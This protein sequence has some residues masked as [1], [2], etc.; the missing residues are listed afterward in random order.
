MTA[1]SLF[2]IAIAL[3][4]DAF[5]LAL[6]MGLT[7]FRHKRVLLFPLVVALFHVFMPLA[8][9]Y[10]GMFL[11]GVLGQ[12]TNFL[13]AG[14]LVFIGGRTTYNSLRAKRHESLSFSAARTALGPAENKV[15]GGTLRSQLVLAT[16]VSIDALSVGFGLGTVGA[17]IWEAVLIMGIVAG[18]MTG[19]GL[20]LGHAIGGRLGKWA[21]TLGGLILIV[22]GLKLVL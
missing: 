12:L 11:G 14:I 7:G 20:L 9:L 6:G 4:T 8:G 15:L 22:V 3:G 13:G 2:A 10:A 16:G 1:I 19:L 18:L 5:S 21:E 17:R